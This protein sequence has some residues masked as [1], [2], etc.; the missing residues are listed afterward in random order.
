MQVHRGL[1]DIAGC[2]NG[3][4]SIGNFDG[5]HRGH[6]GMI[7]ALL[8]NAT[9][10]SAPAVIFTFDP[11]PITLLRPE[12]SPPPLT[13][14]ER[15]L[16]LL[17]ECG[18]EH[19]VVYPTDQAL[20]A[21]SPREFFDL[22]VVDRLDVRGLVE[23][24][25]FFFGHNRAGSIE[26]LHEFCRAAGRLLEV[27]PPVLIGDRLVSSTEIRRLIAAG[28]VREAGE[29]LGKSYRIE[30]TVVRGAERGGQI[31]FP[32]ANLDNVGT[33][34]PGDGVYAG[35][36]RV[37]STWYAAGINI[38]PNPTFADRQHKVEVHLIDFSHDLYGTRLTIELID[39]LRDTRRF[40]GLAALQTQLADDVSRARALAKGNVSR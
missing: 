11:H 27:V 7:A 33:V 29:L 19:V 36:A 15:K 4:V 16:E 35:R 28:Q 23:G 2:R 10:H 26:T 40:D 24:P 38:G 6:Q 13:T 9:G 25:N 3:F 39:R 31:G 8:R 17:S 20:L 32:T 34:V 12:R 30:G 1:D 14:T 37:G 5:V 22:I 18:A 21:L